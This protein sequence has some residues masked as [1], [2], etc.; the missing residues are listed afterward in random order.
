VALERR[1]YDT[2][3]LQG[4]CLYYSLCRPRYYIDLESIRNRADLVDWLEHIERKSCYAHDVKA[5]FDEIFGPLT[6]PFH[7]KVV[8]TRVKELLRKPKRRSR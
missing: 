8:R 4:Y 3:Y 6:E 1:Y 7:K 2:W 5:A